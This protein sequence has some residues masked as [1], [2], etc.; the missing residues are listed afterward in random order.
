MAKCGKAS[1]VL[2]LWHYL[3]GVLGRE[4]EFDGVE[5]QVKVVM[6]ELA[7]GASLASLPLRT[8]LLEPFALRHAGVRKHQDDR[9]DEHDYGDHPRKWRRLL[10][11]E[12]AR[13]ATS[14]QGD[15]NNADEALSVEERRRNL[16][17][18]HRARVASGD[19]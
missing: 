14:S 10:R 11:R 13:C 1:S 8:S 3:S 6:G 2:W 5:E 16:T 19:A 4:W 12:V 15:A 18:C 17:Q 9:T 7:R